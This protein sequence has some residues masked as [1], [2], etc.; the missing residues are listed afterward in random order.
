MVQVHFFEM[1]NDLK[2]LF[3]WTEIGHSKMPSSQ[4]YH[5]DNR[6]HNKIK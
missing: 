3:L 5:Y 6:R 1:P 4:F 2:A